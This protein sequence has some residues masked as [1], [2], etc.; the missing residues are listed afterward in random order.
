[1][2][3]SL[4]TVVNWSEEYKDEAF[5]ASTQRRV[6][7]VTRLVLFGLMIA[8]FC[9]A[10]IAL[11]S[12]VPSLLAVIPIFLTGVAFGLAS[13]RLLRLR[14]NV[15]CMHLTRYRMTGINHV[16]HP[17]IF[18]WKNVER[19]NLTNDGLTITGTNG[20]TRQE[21]IAYIPQSFRNYTQL[22]HR[23]V[24]CAEA[25]SVP[26]CVDGRP[27]QLLS[28]DELDISKAHSRPGK[29]SS[30]FSGE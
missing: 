9:V 29:S 17:F 16:G 5:R 22:A 4:F 15:W 25:Y 10:A 8:V 3:N 24:K 27:W 2:G 19:I 14:R 7:V 23:V 28:L 6:H 26:I 21:D 11:I 13:K 18:Q 20:H 1:M 12:A 30:L